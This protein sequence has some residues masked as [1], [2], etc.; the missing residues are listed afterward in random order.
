MNS[1]RALLDPDHLA[2][3]AARLADMFSGLVKRQAIGSNPAAQ[4]QESGQKAKLAD[5]RHFRQNQEHHPRG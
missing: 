3:D 5:V 4:Q 2:G 1:A